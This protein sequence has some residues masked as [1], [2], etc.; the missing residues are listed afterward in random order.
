METIMYLPS[1]SI[2]YKLSMKFNKSQYKC[3]PLYFYSI[4]QFWPVRDLRFNVT[5]LFLR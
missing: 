2:T 1:T 4:L 3:I 5:S